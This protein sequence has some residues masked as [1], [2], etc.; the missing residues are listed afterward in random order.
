LGINIKH[1]IFNRYLKS[2]EHFLHTKSFYMEQEYIN[3]QL[4]FPKTS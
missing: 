4:S 2:M 3:V 1:K